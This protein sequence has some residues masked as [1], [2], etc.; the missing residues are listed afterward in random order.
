MSTSSPFYAGYGSGPIFLY[1]TRCSGSESS[2]NECSS[3]RYSYEGTTCNH[4]DDITLN[5]TGNDT[6][7]KEAVVF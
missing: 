2:L 3:T 1:S 4:F 6:F 5:C 7:G